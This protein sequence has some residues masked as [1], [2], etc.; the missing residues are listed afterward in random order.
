MSEGNKHLSA[1]ENQLSRNPLRRFY[2]SVFL[3]NLLQEIDD[4]AKRLGSLSN[5]PTGAEKFH[6]AILTAEGNLATK[7]HGDNAAKKIAA[8]L[9]DNPTSFDKPEDLKAQPEAWKHPQ[10][11]P[12]WNG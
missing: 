12:L 11:H 8:G 4:K 10:S 5:N 9:L 2:A 1:L 7:I 6:H 3:K